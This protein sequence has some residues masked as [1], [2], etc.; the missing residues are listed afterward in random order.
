MVETVDERSR[1]SYVERRI[2]Y[3]SPCGSSVAAYL[4]L[5]CA[6]TSTGAVV[7]FHQ[8]NGEWHLG[9]SEVVGIAGNPLQAFGA[10]LAE[11]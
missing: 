10:R 4:L 1:G 5:P 8:H 9:K 7:V 6:D 3:P 2:R 11:R